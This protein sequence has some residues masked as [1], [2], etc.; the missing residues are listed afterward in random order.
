MSFVY[1]FV[2]ILVGYSIK[3]LPVDGNKLNV[4]INKYLSRYV[5]FICLP[6]IVLTK[7]PQLSLEKSLLLPVVVCWLLIPVGW[8]SV[9]LF[10]K[11]NHWSR[12][13]EGCLLLVCCFGN[14][15]FVGFPI[16]SAFYGHDALVYAVIYD[17][18]GSFLTLAIVGG[19][20]VSLYAPESREPSLELNHKS[21][22]GTVKKIVVKVMSFPP[23]IAILISPLFYYFPLSIEINQLFSIIGQT[24]IPSTM[25]LVGFNL[26]FKLP[27]TL[28]KPLIAGVGVKMILLPGVLLI[29]LLSYFSIAAYSETTSDLIIKVV[30]MEAAMPAMVSSSILA[31]EANLAPKLAA[32]AVGYGLIAAV[33]IMPLIYFLSGVLL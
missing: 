16:I 26:V 21:K 33:F 7:L 23:F 3:F 6:A 11:K 19:I 20:I 2:F 9:K 30:L 1:I 15:S 24:L 32:A 13:V 4:A 14:N 22:S 27:G 17:Q 29:A 28:L 10:A 5:I 8:L 25:L 12:E 18:L 31:I